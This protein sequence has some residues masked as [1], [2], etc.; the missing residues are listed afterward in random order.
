MAAL[1]L[2]RWPFGERSATI[3]TNLRACGLRR[4][5]AAPWNEIHV[6]RPADVPNRPWLYPTALSAGQQAF[7]A[8]ALRTRPG[9]VI[10]SAVSRQSWNLLVDPR[11]AA[12][13]YALVSQTPPDLDPRLN[14]PPR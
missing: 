7:G 13:N 4:T 14:P 10:P 6:I 9:V 2:D 1:A 11:R 3:G 8:E 5:R 12:G